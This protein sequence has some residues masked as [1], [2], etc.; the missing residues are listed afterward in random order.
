MHDEYIQ[1]NRKLWNDWTGIHAQ[2]EFYDVESFKEGKFR[3]HPIEKEELG[4]VRGKTL[5]HLQCHFGLDT[6]SWANLGAIVTGADFS[7]KAIDLAR[8]LSRETGLP[9]T[10]ICSNIYDLPAALE[11][12]FDIV[13]TSHGVLGWLPDMPNWGKVV[14]HFLKPGGTFYVAEVH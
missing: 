3:L 2:S 12:Q 13:F 5:L 11:G 7:D 1:S 9:A 6:L 8:E 14:A 10:F 4:D